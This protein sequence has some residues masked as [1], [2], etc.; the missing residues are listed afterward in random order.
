V[1]IIT[2]KAVVFDLD[3]TLVNLGNF[4][5]WREAH[6]MA[7]KVYLSTDCPEETVMSC[8]GK[9]LFNMLNL[10]RDEISLNMTDR[11]VQR[12]QAEAFK[13]VESFEMNGVQRCFL[14]PGCTKTLEWLRERGVK[15]AVA[16]SNSQEVAKHILESRGIRHYFSTVV[17]RRPEL[18]MKPYPDQILRCLEK[19]GVSPGNSI[20][21]G[22]SARD[23][24]AAK[25]A[26]MFVI[27]IP[28]HFTKREVLE[29]AGADMILESM[30]ELPEIL[31]GLMQPKG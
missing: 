2:L 17:G 30:E 31:S 29:E 12:I 23:V 15:M 11:E 22:D 16:T 1:S 19:M 14:M 5:N 6:E 7:L 20:V 25:A 3:A 4:V 9:G 8:S 10:V 24:R 26:N 13:A 21:V 28:A 27:A 18:R